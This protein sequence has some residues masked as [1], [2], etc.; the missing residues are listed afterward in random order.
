MLWR[1]PVFLTGAGRT[2]TGVHAADFYAH[3]DTRE[4]LTTD[5]RKKWVFKLNSFLP[6]DIGVFDILPVTGDAH[7]RF[8]AR[9]RTYKYHIARTR[10]P[11]RRDY[12]HFIYGAIDHEKMN[13]G[14]GIIVQYDDF[15]SFAKV[16]TDAKTN[17]CSIS[18]A[19]WSES[20]EELVFTITADRFLRNMVRAIV[21][22]L[23]EIGT[24]KISIAELRSI[25]ESKNRS[26][27]GDSVPASGL[28]LYHIDYP[29]QLFI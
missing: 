4:P 2:D 11:F 1:S 22:T 24:G 10:N 19:L 13:E 7:A 12:T 9:S 28:I 15:T 5:E 8:S 6:P 23:L 25:I 29:E 14:A 18:H 3:F 21:G 20:G 26:N 16:D 27:A 17:I